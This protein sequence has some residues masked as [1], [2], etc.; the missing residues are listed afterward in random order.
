MEKSEM[1][2]NPHNG[3][4]CDLWASHSWYVPGVKGM[5]IL[6]AWIMIGNLLGSIVNIVFKQFVSE[7]GMITYV[8]TLQKS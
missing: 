1:K 6:F 8:M 4:I 2:L 5:F 7:D 3:H